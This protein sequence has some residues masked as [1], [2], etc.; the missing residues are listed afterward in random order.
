MSDHTFSQIIGLF[1]N[2]FSDNIISEP[3]GLEGSRSWPSTPEI[4]LSHFMP[5]DNFQIEKLKIK[6]FL[7][8]LVLKKIKKNK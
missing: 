1:Q 5:V 4:D 7:H 3:S 6:M 2:L 8:A